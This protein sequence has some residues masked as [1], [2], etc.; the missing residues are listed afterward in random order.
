MS[1]DSTTGTDLVRVLNR[2]Q[3][4]G[5]VWRVVER[6]PSRI[7]VALLRCDGGEEVQRLSSSNPIWLAFLRGRRSSEE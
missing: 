4:S 7:T 6:T 5:A 2:W 3:D 1:D